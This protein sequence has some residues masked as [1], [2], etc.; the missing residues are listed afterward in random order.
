M[1]KIALATD[2]DG[3]LEAIL[4]HHFGRCPYYVLV[5]I[6]NREI[7]DVKSV[8]NPFYDNHGSPGEVPSFIKSLDAQVI[9]SGGMGPKAISFFEQFGI[10]TETGVSG[11]VRNAVELYT[12]GQISGAE[13]CSDHKSLTDMHEGE[14]DEMTRLQEEMVALRK[15]LAKAAERLNRIEKEKGK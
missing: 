8:K 10:E 2:D 12:D 14:H 9:I 6:D 13:P 5:D 1:I 7:K 15:D 11:K 4:S 3:G